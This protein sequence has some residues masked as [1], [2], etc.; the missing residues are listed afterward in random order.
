VL[1]GDN[2]ACSLLHMLYATASNYSIFPNWYGSDSVSTETNS[3][4]S[5]YI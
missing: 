1:N 4:Y 3:L 5:R 2:T